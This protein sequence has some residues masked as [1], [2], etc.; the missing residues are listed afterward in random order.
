MSLFDQPDEKLPT[1]MGQLRR[2]ADCDRATME[3]IWFDT[4]ERRS[5]PGM[6]VAGLFR[7]TL[8]EC[9]RCSKQLKLLDLTGLL[10]LAVVPAAY[11]T[12]VA[13]MGEP[14]PWGFAFLA[15]G[16]AVFLGVQIRLRITHRVVGRDTGARPPEA[17]L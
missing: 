10:L 6:G 11:V 12:W 9:A 15:L 5:R 3:P 1:E 13:A 2:C 8:F 16:C 7:R 17:D 14:R 4:R